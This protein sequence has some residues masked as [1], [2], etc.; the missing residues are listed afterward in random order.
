MPFLAHVHMLFFGFLGFQRKQENH[1]FSHGF[2]GIL[3]VWD[4]FGDPAYLTRSLYLP[5]SP[6]LAFSD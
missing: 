3:C 6:P 2:P 1:A 5:L 4:F